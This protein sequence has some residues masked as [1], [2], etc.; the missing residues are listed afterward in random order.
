[1]ETQYVTNTPN[2]EST[3]GN[4]GLAPGY[5]ASIAV[6]AIGAV[7]ISVLLAFWLLRLRRKDKQSAGAEEKDRAN[8]QGS[9][10]SQEIERSKERAEL[11]G[12]AM[13]FEARDGER[14]ELPIA[15]A[16]LEGDKRFP[17]KKRKKSRKPKKSRHVR[18]EENSV[19]SEDG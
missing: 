1:V 5:I 2:H 3:S 15:I 12:S 11:H 14:F 17:R 16:E 9:A 19:R 13:L 10:K 18:L 4:D 6:G 7:G 8:E